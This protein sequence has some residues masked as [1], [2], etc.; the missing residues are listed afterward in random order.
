[1]WDVSPG[2]EMSVETLNKN[3]R[4]IHLESYV[5]KIYNLFYVLEPVIIVTKY[6]A[7]NI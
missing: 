5:P 7:I 1:M 6:Y 3:R 2:P 4:H